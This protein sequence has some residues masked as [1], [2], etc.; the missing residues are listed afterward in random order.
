VFQFLTGVLLPL[1]S[2]DADGGAPLFSFPR[3]QAGSIAY[4]VD[5]SSSME[6]ERLDRM[7]SDLKSAIADLRDGTQFT[8]VAFNDDRQELPSATG[9]LIEATKTSRTA[10]IDWVDGIKAAGSTKAVP[11]IR[12]LV[13]RQPDSLVFLTDGQFMPDERAEITNMLADK[14]F[15]G[16]TRIDTVMLYPDGEESTLVDLAAKTGGKFRRVAFDP[17][18]PLGFNRVLL[19]TFCATLAG[20]AFG[21]W[22]PWIIERLAG[23]SGTRS[24]VA[25]L[26]ALFESYDRF[27]N[28][29]KYTL[30][31]A[32]DFDGSR[33]SNYAWAYQRSLA[34]RALAQVEASLTDPTLLHEQPR[35]PQRGSIPMEVLAAEDWRDVHK[36]LDEPLPELRDIAQHQERIHDIVAVHAEELAELWRTFAS[37][38][39]PLSHGHLPLDAIAERFGDAVGQRLMQASRMILLPQRRE[40]PPHSEGRRPFYEM[41]DNLADRISD[42]AHRPFLSAR[43]VAPSGEMP[44]RSLTWIGTTWHDSFGD[45]DDLAKSYFRQHTQIRFK[46]DIATSD[47]GIRALGLIHEEMEVVLEFRNSDTPIAGDV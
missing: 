25:H 11:G 40:R 31:K 47:M 45:V 29:T 10:A 8:V 26:A 28:D 4:L 5:R 22:L 1:R 14:A 2:E 43:V 39:D 20:V 42:D 17:L 6:G 7:K 15:L 23:F 18:A 9:R 24:L 38:Q 21:A 34:T 19:I 35:S 32:D 16:K 44:P 41:F 46:D 12:T 27:G 30:N 37:D 13:G 3:K 36:A 33:R